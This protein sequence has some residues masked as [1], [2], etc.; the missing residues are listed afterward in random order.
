MGSGDTVVQQV[1]LCEPE[2]LHANHHL[3]F[4]ILETL[5]DANIQSSITIMLGDIVVSFSSIIDE[6]SDKLYWGLSDTDL[7]MKKD[8][9][10]VLT[11]LILN[12]MIKVKGQLGEIA[13]CLED[14]ELC[15]PDLAKL[16]FMDLSMKDNTIYNNLPDGACTSFFFF[17]G[18][19]HPTYAYSVHPVISHL[20]VGKHAM[21][22][23]GFQRPMRYIFTFIKKVTCPACPRPIPIL[24][25]VFQQEKQAESFIEKLC[26]CFLLQLR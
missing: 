7:I 5:K 19:L 3:L 17:F 26:Q 25:F 13:K 23:D 15:I 16:F 20:S 1:P 9:L 10:T 4:R 18:S 21:N 11:H 2:L 8:M 24:T 6:N 12:G 22:E 14:E